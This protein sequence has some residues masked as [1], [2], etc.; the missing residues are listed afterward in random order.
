M[1]EF[2]KEMTVGNVW[3]CLHILAG[4]ILARIFY[5]IIP[6]L[7]E[8]SPY[9]LHRKRNTVLW[10]LAIVVFWEVFELFFWGTSGYSGGTMGWFADSLGDVLGAVLIALIVVL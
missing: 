2:L 10:V 8:G 5:E 7:F 1:I 6:Y 9:Y 4:G 3:L